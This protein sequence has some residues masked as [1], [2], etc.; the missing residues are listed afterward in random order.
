VNIK[1]RF[2]RSKVVITFLIISFFFIL[3]KLLLIQV[4]QSDYLSKKADRQ[5][6][7]FLELESKRGRIFDR[8]L[9]PLSLNLPVESL[10]AIPDE[11]ENKEEAVRRL[12]DL[13]GLSRF[14]LEDRLNRKKSFVWLARKL[15]EKKVSKIKDLDIKGLNFIK[16]NK[17]F[18]PNA[19]LASHIIGFSGIDNNGLEGMELYYN[20]YLEGIPGRCLL[21]R[22]AQQ[23]KISLTKYFFP[24]RDGYDLVLTIDETIQ[25]IA[26]RELERIFKRY[27]AKAAMIVVIDP[28][29]GEILALANRPNF[30][31]NSYAN[32]KIDYRRNRVISDFFEPGSVFKIVTAS[33]ALEE[34][35]VS[36]ED[37]FF[38]EEGQYR[39]A[40]HILHDH[41]PHG[42]LKFRQVIVQSSNIG[43]TKVAQILGPKIIYR[44]MK[45]FGFGSLTQIDLVGEVSGV[46][47]KPSDWS[48]TSIGAIPIG[49]EVGVTALQLVCAIA[50][51]ANNGLYMKPFVVKYVKDKKGELIKEF[52]PTVIRR[53]ISEETARRMKDILTGVVEQGTGRYAKIKGLKVAGKTGTA[54]KFIDGTYSHSKFYAS[55]IGFA[56]VDDPIVAIAVVV[57]EPRG[58]HYGGVVSAPVFKNVLQDTLKYLETSRTQIDLEL[59]Q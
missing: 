29:T 43:T 34:K 14:Y 44:Y 11:I 7:L 22:D 12:S 5:H 39:V 31:L 27:R 52:H 53:V 56:P 33:A 36:E 48:G 20:D 49:Q 25:F 41:K 54:Q 26:E 9:R 21:L 19:H 4:F 1:K 17:R 46:V 24:P 57:D 15:S 8:N 2:P 50:S 42:W 40:N 55:F 6:D 45:L 23:R 59:A 18:Y 35:K 38:C 37:E 16:E 30:D 32:Y 28:K 51:I 47:K 3:I 58:S 13:L 10:Y